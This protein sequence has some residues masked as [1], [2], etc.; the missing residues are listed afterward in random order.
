MK[1][2]ILLLFILVTFL[3]LTSCDNN[4]PTDESS[5]DAT[6]TEETTTV[7]ETNTED[8]SETSIEETTTI[9]ETTS[10]EKQETFIKYPYPNIILKD[11]AGGYDQIL[12]GKY[13]GNEF[14]QTKYNSTYKIITTYDELVEKVEFGELIEESLFEENYVLVAFTKFAIIGVNRYSN[15]GIRNNYIE[16]IGGDSYDMDE[17]DYE[18]PTVRYIVIPKFDLNENVKLTGELKVLIWVNDSE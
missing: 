4:E 5:S 8:S 18:V 10:Q 2:L 12:G 13:L 17:K 3:V 14:E 11:E 16:F 9:E 7:D 6:S 1:K 15:F